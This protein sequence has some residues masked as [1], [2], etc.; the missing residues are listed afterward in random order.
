MGSL[1]LH[2][3]TTQHFFLHAH[4]A[5]LLMVDMAYLVPQVRI[6]EDEDGARKEEIAA[7]KGEDNTGFGW[8]LNLP[9]TYLDC[10]GPLLKFTLR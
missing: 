2:Q 4:C 6:Y 5:V 10:Q 8:L 7:L 9:S 1:H 3:R